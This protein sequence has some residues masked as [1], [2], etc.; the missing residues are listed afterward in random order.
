MLWRLAA[1]AGG[2][3]GLGSLVLPYA[4]VS[5]GTLGITVTEDEY[6]LFGLAQ[7]LQ[8]AGEDPQMV[9]A[10]AVVIVVGSALALAGAF[11]SSWLAGGGGLLQVGGA[12][13][14][15]YGATTEGSQTFFYGLGNLDVT[16]EVGV[17][18]LAVAGVVSLASVPLKLVT[19]AVRSAT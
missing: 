13:A 17:F 8:D 5:G 7:L 4:L 12:V 15:A 1:G 2:A 14:F 16:L 11:V 6:T 18:V 10:L 3:G 19:D 9:Y